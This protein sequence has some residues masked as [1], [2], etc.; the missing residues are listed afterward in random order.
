MPESMRPGRKTAA[1]AGGKTRS[2]EP[3]AGTARRRGR[4]PLARAGTDLYVPDDIRGAVARLK[5]ERIVASAVDLFY[6]Q[7]YGRTTLEQVADA[8]DVTKPFIYAHFPSKADLLAEICSRAIRHAHEGLNRILLQEGTHTERLERIFKEFL[9]A[10]LDNQAHAVIFSREETELRQADRDSINSLRRAFDQK[11][12]S[13]LE[14]GVAAEE[15][16]IEDIPLTAI[17]IGGLVGWAP[18]WYRSSG[19]LD[20]QEVAD[21]LTGL[22]LNMVQARKTRG[23]RNK[24]ETA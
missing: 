14:A 7:G 9:M 11:L 15:F 6:R 3:A 12:V 16:T 8:M 17:A 23:R 4:P 19:R 24:K 2:A 1:A 21:R 10:V 20:M 22:V 18:V 5:R 13:L